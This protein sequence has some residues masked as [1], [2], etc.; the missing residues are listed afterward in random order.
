M[1]SIPSPE[2][3]VGYTRGRRGTSARRGQS[4]GSSSEGPDAQGLSYH[5]PQKRPSGLKPHEKRN[6]LEWFAGTNWIE[7]PERGNGRRDKRH[8]FFC[9]ASRLQSRDADHKCQGHDTNSH[10]ES[11][12][13]GH[14]KASGG[15]TECSANR[16]QW[17]GLPRGHKRQP[18]R[19]IGESGDGAHCVRD[20]CRVSRARE[21]MRSVKAALA[22]QGDK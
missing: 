15:R 19:G 18:R 20:A 22:T 3:P 6:V 10:F 12:T 1:W 14:S 2:D 7:S 11:T 8:L 17:T 5:S 4:G 9:N 21:A 13:P 16:C